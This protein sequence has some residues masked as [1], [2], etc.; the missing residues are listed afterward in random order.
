MQ[1]LHRHRGAD[2]EDE[3]SFGAGRLADLR[4]AV[5]DVCWLLDRGY[6]I[7]SAT[8]LAG[9]NCIEFGSRHSGSLSEVV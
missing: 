5:Y 2:P 4:Q 8:E 3:R 1:K 7:A 6:G 9:A